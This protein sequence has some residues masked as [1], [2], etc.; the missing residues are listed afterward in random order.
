MTQQW[1][2]PYDNVITGVSRVFCRDRTSHHYLYN[3]VMMTK[4]KDR[5]IKYAIDISID[6]IKNK[7]FGNDVLCVTGPAI[8]GEA[9]RKTPYHNYEL[10]EGVG[11][12]ILTGTYNNTTILR[13]Y[14]Y[15]ITDSNGNKLFLPK[16]EGH[17]S[18]LYN[19]KNIPYAKAW[20]DKRVFK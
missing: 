8:L 18:H 3:A 9:F 15:T 2:Q 12:N 1:Y 10:K 14:D 13:W 19:S 4:P 6:N 5:V 11:R 7:N 16:T 17:I 20:D